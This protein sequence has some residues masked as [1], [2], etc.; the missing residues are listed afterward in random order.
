MM[1]DKSRRAILASAMV[2][3]GIALGAP[4]ALAGN[5][6]HLPGKC[7]VHFGALV[8]QVDCTFA[9]QAAQPPEDVHDPFESMHQE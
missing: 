3:I 9:P 7:T 5:K 8:R 1:T 6:V 4:T 2:A